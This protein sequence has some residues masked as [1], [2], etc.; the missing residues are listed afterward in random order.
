MLS[1]HHLAIKAADV[2][3][4][5]AFY[6]G[7]GLSELRRFYEPAEQLRSVWLQLGEA[8][9]MIERA[10]EP[11]PTGPQPKDPP[12]GFLL[13]LSMHPAEREGWQARLEA[14]GCAITGQS[15]FSLYFSDP[16]GNRLALSSWPEPSAS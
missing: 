10:T 7:L 3:Q 1:I 11:R 13:A 6:Q 14:A 15:E 9:L 12:G 5:A 2:A 8:I 16:E 4:L